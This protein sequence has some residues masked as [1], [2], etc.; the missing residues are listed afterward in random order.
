[1]E[2]DDIITITVAP[3][4]GKTSILAGPVAM[5]RPRTDAEASERVDSL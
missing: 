1:V 3:L 5:P 2:D 4:T